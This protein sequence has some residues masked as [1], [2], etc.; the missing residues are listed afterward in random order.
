MSIYAKIHFVLY[1]YSALCSYVEHIFISLH[2]GV[3]HTH[4]SDFC[5]LYVLLEYDGF[6]FF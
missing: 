4:A 2:S 6:M 1:F 3:M 5:L